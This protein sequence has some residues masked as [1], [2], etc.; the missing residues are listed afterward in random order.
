MPRGGQNLRMI[1]SQVSSDE[2]HVRTGEFFGFCGNLELEVG[3]SDGGLAA[4]MLR[5]SSHP[6]GRMMLQ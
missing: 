5:L 3:F 6:H 2:P 4:S 1:G